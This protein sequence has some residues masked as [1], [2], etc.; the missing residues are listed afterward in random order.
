MAKPPRPKMVQ[1]KHAKVSW[2][3]LSG[4]SG[5]PA[6][7]E[8]CLESKEEFPLIPGESRGFDPEIVELKLQVVPFDQ[9]VDAPRP[10]VGGILLDAEARIERV[11]FEDDLE[12]LGDHETRAL[13]VP[14]GGV[15]PIE[16]QAV[17][18]LEPVPEIL[19]PEVE[20][21]EVDLGV[22]AGAA[23]V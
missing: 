9:I 15:E 18:W 20:A 16:R 5:C 4:Q 11:E 2:L 17:L 21:S 10:G 12:F 1:P 8:D 22:R 23:P 13:S 7:L 14:A 19:E 6:G 3:F